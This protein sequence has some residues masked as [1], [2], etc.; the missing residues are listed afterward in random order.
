MIE[1]PF[2]LFDEEME[3]LFRDAVIGPEVSLCLVPEILDA[4][5]MIVFIGEYQGMIDPQ[6]SE[7]GHIEHIIAYEAVGVDD[8]VRPDLLANDG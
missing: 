5:D 7:L 3:V 2:T 1:A 8:A 4:V 6:V